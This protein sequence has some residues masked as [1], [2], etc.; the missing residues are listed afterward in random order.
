MIMNLCKQDNGARKS[1]ENE[2]NFEK[3]L[4]TN[5]VICFQF[6]IIEMANLFNLFNLL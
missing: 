5:L 6:L 2:I 1:I 4:L 3:L